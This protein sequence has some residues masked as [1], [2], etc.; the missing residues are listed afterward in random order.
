MAHPQRTKLYDFVLSDGIQNY[1]VVYEMYGAHGEDLYDEATRAMQSKKVYDGF[2]I[3]F[4][5]ELF[6]KAIVKH[7]RVPK[8][9]NK[10]FGG[11][12]EK[13]MLYF[14]CNLDA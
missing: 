2:G 9:L 14:P 5:N 6:G 7:T 13:V 3:D 10:C 12:W 1:G 11:K 8:F 4:D